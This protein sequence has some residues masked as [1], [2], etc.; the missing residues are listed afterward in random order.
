MI[1]FSEKKNDRITIAL[2]TISSTI[3]RISTPNKPYGP[4]PNPTL[5][6]IV[7]CLES[8]CLTFL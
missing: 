3:L 8:P 6:V 4:Y 7:P 1:H 5:V 2:N